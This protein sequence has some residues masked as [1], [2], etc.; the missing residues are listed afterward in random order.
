[1]S[2]HKTVTWCD[3]PAYNRAMVPI[4]RRLGFLDLAATARIAA[5]DCPKGCRCEGCSATREEAAEVR[6]RKHQRGMRR[7]G[8]GT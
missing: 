5:N 8:V 7:Q 3:H 2:D 4:L 6:E 1:M